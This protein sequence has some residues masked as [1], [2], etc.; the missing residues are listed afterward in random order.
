MARLRATYIGEAVA[1]GGFALV[2][3]EPRVIPAEADAVW[4]EMRAARRHSDLIIVNQAHAELVQ[5]RLQELISAE[6]TPPVVV[7]PSM[8]T[9]EAAMDRVIGPARRVLGLS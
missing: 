9:D 1:A 2:G 3:V 7:V 5:A 8:N 6:S 4:R